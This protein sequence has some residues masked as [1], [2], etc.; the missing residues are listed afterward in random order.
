[1]NSESNRN[2]IMKPARIST[3]RTSNFD[4]TDMK[5]KKM[6]LDRG[7]ENEP[8]KYT[9][10]T[11]GKKQIKSIDKTLL[12]EVANQSE[13]NDKS[14][15]TV[16]NNKII[17]K[18][19]P[20]GYHLFIPSNIEIVH[21][22]TINKKIKSVKETKLI[23]NIRSPYIMWQRENRH[24]YKE[25]ADRIMADKPLG[26]NGKKLNSM[27]ITSQL[28]GTVWKSLSNEDKQPYLDRYKLERMEQL[29]N[30]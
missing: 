22:K 30:K 5:F 16:G 10:L 17:I 19:A 9:K 3:R 1:M 21:E 2:S 8:K 27:I 14:V 4:L 18:Q 29:N 23:K 7:C 25:A 13:I 12:T 20:E 15:E 6:H 28:L 24:L 26:K 11:T